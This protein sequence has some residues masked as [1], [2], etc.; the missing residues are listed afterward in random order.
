MA[1]PPARVAAAVS[2]VYSKVVGNGVADLRP[3]PRV[4]I[5]QG[6]MRSVYRFA[7]RGAAP[8]G[9][10]ILLVP[11]LAA[12]AQAFDLRRGCSLAEH[13]VASG[14]AVYLVDY[15]NVEGFR[16]HDEG[17]RLLEDFLI[18]RLNK[19]GGIEIRVGEPLP[20]EP[21]GVYSA[22]DV[23]S[24]EAEHRTMYTDGTTLVAYF[25]F[26]DGEYDVNANV[27]GIAYYNTSMAVFAEKIDDNTGGVFQA[28]RADV[29]G[30]VAKH[31]FGHILGLVNNGSEMQRNHQDEENG[32]HC[33]NE[34]CLM[35]YAV[36]TVDFIS[37]LFEE[38][39]E[40]DDDCVDDLQANGGR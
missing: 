13:L 36:R 6:P 8:S 10:P 1:S 5:D 25:L 17:L 12:P 19:P 16:P 37:Q 35:Y 28:S 33:E 18:Q 21:Q 23:R 7:A 3:M 15:G 29:E 4:L 39:P 2:N 32:P 22:E 26:L 40:L 31:E 11:P 27:L 34:N 20:I 9:P 24:L 38:L 14:R 30:T